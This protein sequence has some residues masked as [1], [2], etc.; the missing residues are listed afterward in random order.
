MRRTVSLVL[1]VAIAGSACAGDY[2][3]RVSESRRCLETAD[4]R[5]FLVVGDTAWSLVAQLN[6]DAIAEYLDDRRRGF[7][8]I[9]VSLVERR[10]ADNAPARIDGARPFLDDDLARPNPRPDLWQACRA[11]YRNK[12]VRPFVM[13]GSAYEG[14][15]RATA[16]RIRRQAWWAVLSG[17]C[18]QFFGNNPIRYFDGPASRTASPPP[19]GG[20]RWTCRAP[21]T[22]ADSPRCSAHCPGSDSSPT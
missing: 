7:N 11:C 21:A 6:E 8:S 10:F 1:A 12:A 4:G 13:I 19:A 2:P 15:H 14:E 9:V 18:G 22:W 5:P 16:D 20:R 3:S 17:G